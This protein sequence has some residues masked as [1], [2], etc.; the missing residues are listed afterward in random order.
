[1]IGFFKY[2]L[3]GYSERQIAD[4]SGKPEYFVQL[5]IQSRLDTNKIICIDEFYERVLYL[6]GGGLVKESLTDRAEIER[7]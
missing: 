5:D 3:E 6:M 2:I 4:Q 1:M 7:K